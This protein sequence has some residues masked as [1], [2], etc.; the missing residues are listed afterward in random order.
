M[1]SIRARM[2][3]DRYR[4]KKETKYRVR[5]CT[6][7]IFHFVTLARQLLTYDVASLSFQDEPPSCF[8]FVPSCGKYGGSVWKKGG[9]NSCVSNK[10]CFP[11]FFN[12][13]ITIA[14]VTAYCFIILL[15]ISWLRKSQG[16][17][18]EKER[19]RNG[20]WSARARERRCI[21]IISERHARDENNSSQIK[22]IKKRN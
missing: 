14:T 21:V 2:V 7:V 10:I 5:W 11:F 13:Y 6:R 12:Y 1:N 20:R 9:K 15:L 19:E 8:P 18:S 16:R 3:G 22:M 4:K 17:K